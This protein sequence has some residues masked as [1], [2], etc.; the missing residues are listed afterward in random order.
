MTNDD[1]RKQKNIEK[2]EEST[3]LLEKLA[4]KRRELAKLY[5]ASDP[6]FF[7][8]RSEV[9]EIEKAA[10]NYYNRRI[11]FR[12]PSEHPDDDEDSW[13]HIGRSERSEERRVG[14]ECRL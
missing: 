9:E 7:L 12:Q 4:S 8:V 3:S 11:D 5:A 13:P 10:S 6:N 2:Y 1:A 14:K